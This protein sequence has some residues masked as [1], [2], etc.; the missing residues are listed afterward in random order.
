[1]HIQV[2]YHQSKD[3]GY[4]WGKVAVTGMEHS[5]GGKA[6]FLNLTGDYKGVCLIEICQTIH[7]FF[8]NVS[9]CN[10]RVKVTQ[11]CPTLCDPLDYT[12]RGILQAS[13]VEWVA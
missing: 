11:S 3:N 7:L 6:L 5:E 2:I 13:I 4:I 10:K 12:V 9:F 8:T 1:M